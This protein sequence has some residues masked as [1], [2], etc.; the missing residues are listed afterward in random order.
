MPIHASFVKNNLC[1][2]T[3]RSRL[4]SDADPCGS[5]QHP[6]VHEPTTTNKGAAVLKLARLVGSGNDGSL[7]EK[8]HRHGLCHDLLQMRR[9]HMRQK[10]W[11]R[12]QGAIG[13]D[14]HDGVV[15]DRTQRFQVFEC[16]GLIPR[17][18]ECQNLTCQL[19]QLLQPPERSDSQIETSR[20]V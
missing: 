18:F 20:H 13:I 5:L 3:G 17:M 4:G 7:T 6:R 8:L 9:F 12:H 19:H 11:L 16:F 1:V 10:F 14:V 2:L 15:E